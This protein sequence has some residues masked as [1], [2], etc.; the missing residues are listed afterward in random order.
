MSSRPHEHRIHEHHLVVPRTAR[1]ATLGESGPAVREVWFVLHGFGQLS[2]YFIRHFGVLADGTRLVVAPEALNRFYLEQTSWKGAGTARVGATWMTREER[3]AEMRD[4]VGYLDL[5]YDRVFA[6]LVRA[7]VRVT[8][9]GFSQGV[10]TGARWL[11][12]GRVRADAFVSWA[13]P[14]P[15]ELDAEAV[16]PLRG[17]RLVRVLGDG[18][19]MALPDHVAAEDA[20]MRALG[21]DAPLIRFPG[22]HALHRDTLLA[23]AT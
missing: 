16:R 13:G 3:E 6:E 2:P 21:L 14:F 12:R 20:R 8:V 5:L 1:Y 9:L 18:D 19:E 4:Y 17:L 15:P 11:C 22:G 10:A 7:A 23:I